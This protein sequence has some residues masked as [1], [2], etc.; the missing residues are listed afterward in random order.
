MNS[1]ST[2]HFNTCVYWLE[3][4][5]QITNRYGHSLLHNTFFSR[6][7][8][9]RLIFIQIELI[10][11]QILPLQISLDLGVIANKRYSTQ[12][13]LLK[14]SLTISHSFVS[15]WGHP[16]LGWRDLIPLQMIKW[17]AIT[18]QLG[19]DFF[20]E[21]QRY[22]KCNQPRSGSYW[23]P[24][25]IRQKLFPLTLFNK[26]K[27]LLS[28]FRNCI[29]LNFCICILMIFSEFTALER[30]LISVKNIRKYW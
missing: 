13:Y 9:I 25:K 14:W 24:V 15:H 18:E 22:L 17:A 1:R 12:T 26:D 5:V 4:R 28:S 3:I 7:C 30:D 6:S 21:Y 23:L 29:F 20:Q 8:R 19:S 11:R 16:L 10:H 2:I 27:L